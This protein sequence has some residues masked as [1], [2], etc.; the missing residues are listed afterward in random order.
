MGPNLK[1]ERSK[2]TAIAVEFKIYVIGGW[3]KDKYYIEKLNTNS[4]NPRWK[5]FKLDGTE[6][7]PKAGFGAHLL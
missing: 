4:K 6:L 7:L 3:F 2:S 5:K 1:Q